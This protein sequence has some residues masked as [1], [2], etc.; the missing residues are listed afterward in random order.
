MIRAIIARI[1]SY[2]AARNHRIDDELRREE[3]ARKRYIARLRRERDRLTK[4]YARERA[5]HK[6]R[7]RTAARLQSTTHE[8]LK[9]GG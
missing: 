4:Q 8:L 5:H 3:W 7:S 9:Y 1:R 2:F 6:R